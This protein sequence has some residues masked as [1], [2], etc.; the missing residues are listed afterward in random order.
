ML[1][2]QAAQR[3]GSRVKGMGPWLRG[4]LCR[5]QGGAE[6][7]AEREST[8]PLLGFKREHLNHN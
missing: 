1:R 2:V 8:D 5:F 7:E 4:A 3:A 6:P